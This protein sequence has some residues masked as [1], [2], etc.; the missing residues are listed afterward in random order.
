MRLLLD[1]MFPPALAVALRDLGHDVVAVKERADLVGSDDENVFAAAQ[2]DARAVVTENVADY[3]TIAGLHRQEVGNHYGLLLV[4]KAGLPRA[5]AQFVGALA[6]RL[7]A[8]LRARPGRDS[9]SLVD[10]P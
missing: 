4:L 3:V 5:R 7:D 1:E 10:W 2:R 9:E 6:R 8:Y